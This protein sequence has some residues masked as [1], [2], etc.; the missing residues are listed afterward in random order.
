MENI[1]F[2][3]FLSSLGKADGDEFEDLLKRIGLYEYVRGFPAHLFETLSN[4]KEYGTLPPNFGKVMET[5][6]NRVNGALATDDNA[7]SKPK[8]KQYLSLFGQ[9][10]Y[11]WL[12]ARFKDF[13][14]K[15]RKE[16]DQKA[17]EMK[18]RE[19]IDSEDLEK[20]LPRSENRIKEEKQERLP[21]N[22]EFQEEAGIAAMGPKSYFND[23]GQQYF[24]SHILESEDI[25]KLDELLK[26][27]YSKT[28]RK[29]NLRTFL[30]PSKK[31][32][33]P[34]KIKESELYFFVHFFW[35]L[36]KQE[37]ISPEPSRF[38][39][40]L[41]SCL[42]DPNGK[43]FSQNLKSISSRINK[44]ESPKHLKIRKEVAAIMKDAGLC[45]DL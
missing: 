6:I 5:F 3:E 26:D 32:Y 34:L 37:K 12:C 38:F 42:T 33:A 23:P 10:L 43:F 1:F 35:V 17:E 16:I 7:E 27:E 28:I 8:V 45:T 31:R 21:V 4:G 41:Q 30:N 2:Q 24:F 22:Q 36:W 11:Q 13:E 44:D 9:D 20:H 40:T 39:E 18:G 15:I 14:D 19:D 29:G 25:S